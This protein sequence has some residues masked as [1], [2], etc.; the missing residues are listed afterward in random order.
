MKR[1]FQCGILNGGI[2]LLSIVLFECGLIPALNTL[3]VIIFGK[4]SFMAQFMWSW[5]EP[6][7][8]F[9]FKAVWVT[10]LYFLSKVVNALWFQV[11]NLVE[12]CK[13]TC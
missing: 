3:F 5:I 12:N 6:L 1:I 11:R 2:F 10:P 9:V 4:E 7:L 8:S 13:D